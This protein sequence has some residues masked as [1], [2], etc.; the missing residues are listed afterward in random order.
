MFF[1]SNSKLS[2]VGFKEFL[3]EFAAFFDCKSTAFAIIV[4]GPTLVLY[5][6]FTQ[7]QHSRTNWAR[8]NC[9]L[10][11]TNTNTQAPLVASLTRR[12]YDHWKSPTY[13]KATSF[14]RAIQI[15]YVTILYFLFSVSS[16]CK[17]Q[18][19][20]VFSKYNV[21]VTSYNKLSFPVFC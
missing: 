7:A 20:S 9:P 4:R 11:C 2:N 19:S 10:A 1:L 3:A 15:I 5:P 14:K 21:F 18:E 13:E 17:Y 8:A 12:L 16:K 6:D